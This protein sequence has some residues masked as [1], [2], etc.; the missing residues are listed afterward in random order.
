MKLIVVG[1]GGSGKSTIVAA[2]AKLAARRVRHV[3]VV[4]ADESNPGIERM[5]GMNESSPSLID[6]VGGRKQVFGTLKDASSEAVQATVRHMLE[7][8]KQRSFLLLQVGKIRQA[9]SG[10]ACPHGV[11]A[12]EILSYSFAPGTFVIVD[13]EA[14]LEHFG[15]GVDARVDM[16]LFVADPSYDAITLCKEAKVLADSI[17]VPFLTVLNKVGGED[18]SKFLRAELARRGIDVEIVI[19]YDS[20]IFES[21][22]LGNPLEVGVAQQAVE[23]LLFRMLSIGLP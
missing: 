16:I 11:I 20:Q 15:R 10:C 22:L 7:E 5:L 2:M 23:Q 12:R 18:I 19:P 1:K 14:G 8:A 9:G 6:A 3:V 21:S 4:D 17:G 13:T